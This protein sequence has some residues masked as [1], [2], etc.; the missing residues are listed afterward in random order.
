[1][2]ATQF[3]FGIVNSP[4]VRIQNAGWQ[5][6][7]ATRLEPTLARIMNERCIG[8]VF[9]PEGTGVEMV[10]VHA[11]D[12]L[13]ERRC[14][15]AFLGR[16]LAIGKAHRRMRVA[17]MQRPHMGDKIAPRS[18][19]NL[20]A[21]ARQHSRHIGDGLLQRQILARNIGAGVRSRRQA[22]QGLGIGIQIL[23]LFNHKLGPGLHHFLHRTTLDGAQNALAIFGRD[24]RRQLDL[25]LENLLVPVFRIDN[26]VLRESDVLG[27]NIAGQAVQLDEVS[28]A[29]GR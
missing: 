10:V 3:A 21:Q 6:I 23:Y 7:L 4:A 18:D 25:N 17:D 19:F 14:Q 20:H 1:M 5:R 22:Q 28:R 8:D 9:A 12:E 13:S 24:I 11:L 27:R 29:Q 26:I 15:C 16:A 2:R